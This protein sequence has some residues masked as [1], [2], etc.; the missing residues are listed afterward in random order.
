M[1]RNLVETRQSDGWYSDGWFV[2]NN[3]CDKSWEAKHALKGENGVQEV[4]IKGNDDENTLET[5]MEMSK[6][7]VEGLILGKNQDE[8]RDCK[9]LITGVESILEAMGAMVGY[10][11]DGPKEESWQGSSSNLGN[12]NG[13]IYQ[14]NFIDSE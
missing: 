7:L 1:Y 5:T 14:M 9:M 12:V 11:F 6:H 8:A 13:L 3:A 4:V 10:D 2:S